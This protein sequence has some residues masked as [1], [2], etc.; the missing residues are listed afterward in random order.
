MGN[1]KSLGLV[2]ARTVA[3]VNNHLLALLGGEEYLQS[4]IEAGVDLRYSARWFVAGI[5]AAG[6]LTSFVDQR[7]PYGARI[8]S[9]LNTTVV[10]LLQGEDSDHR[11]RSRL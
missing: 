4:W 11:L 8:L 6:Q 9:A 1:E 7:L 3:N 2:S 5:R 10:D